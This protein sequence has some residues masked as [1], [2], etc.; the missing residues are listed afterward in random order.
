MLVWW[1]VLCLWQ[2]GGTRWSFRVP[3]NSGHSMILCGGRTVCNGYKLKEGRFRFDIRKK[4]FTVRPVRYWNRLPEKLWVPHPRKCSRAGS[5]KIWCSGRCSWVGMKLSW[6][7]LPTKSIQLFYDINQMAKPFLSRINI[8]ILD[9]PQSQ[10]VLIHSL[11][12]C[13]R[14]F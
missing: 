12:F 4:F 8:D 10:G 9:S 1:Q 6:W 11:L 3:S 7:F 2:R 13:W 14:V 5:W